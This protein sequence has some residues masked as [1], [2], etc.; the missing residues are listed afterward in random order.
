MAI[1]FACLSGR[2]ADRPFLCFTVRQR[3][4][5]GSYIALGAGIF[6]WL[7]TASSSS[8]SSS[9]SSLGLRVVQSELVGEL[10]CMVVALLNPA[11]FGRSGYDQSLFSFLETLI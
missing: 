4:E 6:E 8:S 11:S 2:P 1:L 10:N 9:S 7:V 5:S 3:N